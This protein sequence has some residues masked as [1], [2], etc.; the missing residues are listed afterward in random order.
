VD[1]L[2]QGGSVRVRIA[3]S[4]KEGAGVEKIAITPS[5]A[6]EYKVWAEIRVKINQ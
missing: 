6:V 1:F 4:S 2:K 5:D 3:L